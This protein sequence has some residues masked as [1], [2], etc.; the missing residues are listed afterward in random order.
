MSKTSE[1]FYD[2]FGFLYPVVDLFLKSS[3][4]KF[5][6]EINTYPH[7]RLL[8][9]GVGNG[10]HF[11]YYKT[12]DVT[13]VDTSQGMLSRARAVSDSIRGLHV[14]VGEIG[15]RR[16]KVV[17]P[18]AGSHNDIGC[19]VRLRDE[20]LARAARAAEALLPLLGRRGCAVERRRA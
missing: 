8:E 14:P 11:K 2:R 1:K 17:A 6:L 12:H 20:R 7:G 5:F 16:R 10:A 3:K 9:I 15:Q 19:R 4:Q 13:G 18:T